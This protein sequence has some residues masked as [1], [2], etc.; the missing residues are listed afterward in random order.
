MLT[1]VKNVLD[2]TADTVADLANV[3]HKTGSI[4]LLGFHTKGDGGGGVFYWDATKDKSEHNGGTVIDPNKAGLVAN[5]ASTQALYFTPEVIGQGCWVRE[6]S[7]AVN[8]KWFGAKGDGVADDTNAIQN[9]INFSTNAKKTINVV[10]GNY[11]LTS[12]LISNSLGLVLIGDNNAIFTSTASGAILKQNSDD[13]ATRGFY[14]QTIIEKISFVGDGINTTRCIDLYGAA[15]A[16]TIVRDC[17]LKGAT[18]EMLYLEQCWGV[19][20]INCQIG[21][22][23]ESRTTLN[24]IGIY[25]SNANAVMIRDTI[26][27]SLG[28]DY[29]GVGVVL[30]SS[31]ASSI[32]NCTIENM[33]TGVK[34]LKGNGSTTIAQN[35][36][37]NSAVVQAAR[38]VSKPWIEIGSTGVVRNLVIRE[39]WFLI[40]NNA[41]N[42]EFIEAEIITFEH[43]THNPGLAAPSYYIAS[44][45]VTDLYVGKNH[46]ILKG[47]GGVSGVTSNE[48]ESTKNATVS[49]DSKAIF[50]SAKEFA[51]IQGSPNTA[52]KNYSNSF[53]FTPSEDLE[54]GVLSV[55]PATWGKCKIK[56][57]A[58]ISGDTTGSGT[59][60]Y[61][62]IPTLIQE[63]GT[64]ID[65]S[66][67]SHVKSLSIT[68]ADVPFL[69]GFG[70]NWELDTTQTSQPVAL[71]F[72]RTGTS[73]SDNYTGNIHFYGILL[74]RV[75]V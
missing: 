67:I 7:G 40:N 49:T 16:N 42:V 33:E 20:V 10:S 6:Y 70:T 11:K 13:P 57:T 66:T 61:Y 53:V 38:N 2:I 51:E 5:W 18:N 21:F 48:E 71:R 28:L 75:V 45:N 8:V 64:E 32:E 72:K 9:V 35:Y 25:V 44:E 36:F 12:S 30:N 43:N 60:V 62:A 52:I 3:Q 26:V 56:T 23:S 1:K 27:S 31:E 41:I 73:G 24:T 19:E 39:N 29:S 46:R 14:R 17:F 4:Q 50:I 69:Q 65:P 34:V 59:I 63:D 74:E 55:I 68:T 15:Y 47:I 22:T 54:V 58:L 37:E